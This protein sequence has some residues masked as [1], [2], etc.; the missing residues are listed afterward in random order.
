V[1]GQPREE[2]H[3]PTIVN[4]APWKWMEANELP[5]GIPDDAYLAVDETAGT[6]TVEVFARD[7]DGRKMIHARRLMTELQTFPLKVPPPPGLLDAYQHTVAAVRR[8]RDA[9][10]AIRYETALRLI[11]AMDLD[12]AAVFGALDLPVAADVDT[13]KVSR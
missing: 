4:H 11:A 10:A 13:S 8:E 1:T 3:V 5:R 7:P 9:A 2:R 12:P 6:I